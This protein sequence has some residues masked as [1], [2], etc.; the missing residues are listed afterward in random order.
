[1]GVGWSRKGKSALLF[2]PTNVISLTEYDMNFMDVFAWGRI[3]NREIL[4]ADVDAPIPEGERAGLG[5]DGLDFGAP[6]ARPQSGRP[7][8]I[9]ATGQVRLPRVD[10][11]D[12]EACLL[13]GRRQEGLAIDATRSHQSRFQYIDSL[14]SHD[15]FDVAGGFETVQLA[16][17]FD[18]SALSPQE[19]E[20]AE[21][22]SP[23]KMANK[24]RTIR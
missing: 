21:S 16:Q 15:D 18:H 10:L 14:D 7:R 4:L 5:G 13:I 12:V 3:A 9:N 11:E 19:T 17:Q 1:M 22:I 20:R 8:Q 2:S 23:M 6:G 24:P